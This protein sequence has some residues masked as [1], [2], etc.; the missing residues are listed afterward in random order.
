MPV[1]SEQTL[2]QLSKTCR[3]STRGT[4]THPAKSSCGQLHDQC[5]RLYA[6]GTFLWHVVIFVKLEIVWEWLEV[7]NIRS[8]RSR[9]CGV[10]YHNWGLDSG[11]VASLYLLYPFVSF[12]QVKVWRRKLHGQH[13]LCFRPEVWAQGRAVTSDEPFSVFLCFVCLF[14]SWPSD[15][16]QLTFLSGLE[17]SLKQFCC[18]TLLREC[19]IHRIH[20]VWWMTPMWCHVRRFGNSISVA[21][22]CARWTG[23]E[24]L[25]FH[26]KPWRAFNY[27]C[28]GNGWYGPLDRRTDR[29]ETVGTARR[30]RLVTASDG[31]L[32]THVWLTCD[33]RVTCEDPTAALRASHAFGATNTTLN[34]CNLSN[35]RDQ[36]QLRWEEHGG[37][38]N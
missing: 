25:W 28:G 7:G 36:A 17:D 38:M 19:R 12:C 8:A 37:T 11:F 4:T 22:S 27:R 13:V 9:N 14:E 34:A 24:T 26:V 33:S 15:H 30:T 32:V 35:R 5:L 10:F 18:F 1:T 20:N 23:F 6:A 29:T 21:H 16:S 31:N 2:R 3:V